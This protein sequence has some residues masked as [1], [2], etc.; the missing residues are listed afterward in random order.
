[1][2]YPHS[3]L[4]LILAGF[5]LV[6]MPLGLALWGQNRSLSELAQ[7]STKGVYETTD[8]ARLS[9][10]LMEQA[11]NM[12]RM[13]LGYTIVE[14]P[15]QIKVYA[16]A[17]KKFAYIE[18]QLTQRLPQSPEQDNLVKAINS[19]EQTLWKSLQGFQIEPDDGTQLTHDEQLSR[20]EQKEAIADKLKAFV[21][22]T[23]E[24]Q[25]L[26]SNLAQVSVRSLMAK[27][28]QA[29]IFWRVG[30][31][32]SAV[33][34]LI[35]AILMAI[36]IS[37]P[38]K[39]L[40]HA[41]RRL[42]TGNF[43]REIEVGGPKDLRLLGQ[44]LE[45]L[46]TR[47][48][49]LNDQQNRFLRNVSHDLKTP[50]TAI[51]EG[52]ELLRDGIAGTLHRRQYE[53]VVIIH[54]NALSLQKMIENLLNYQQPHKLSSDKLVKIDLSKAVKEVVNEH[55]VTAWRRL[56]KFDMH[57]ASIKVQ[58]E[59]KKIETIIDNLISNAVKYSP[60]LGTITLLLRVQNGFARLDVLDEGIGIPSDEQERVFDTFF[61][62]M[63]PSDKDQRVK[64]S[65]LGLAVAKEYALAHGGRVQADDRP[66]GKQGARFTVWLPVWQPGAE[67]NSKRKDKNEKK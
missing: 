23:L 39:A 55:R 25:N 60:R 26:A 57:L 7:Q 58:G 47:L 49:E 41:I 22:K 2:V 16:E 21:N 1:V 9:Q 54:D 3:L 34:A 14:D 35:F 63:P 6:A 15:Q 13:A 64:S 45:W 8:V 65:G 51:R 5:L 61:Q 32:A 10:Q 46:R 53:I 59:Q 48:Q 27:A 33:V 62:G 12:E 4:K 11:R 67:E 24:F 30:L 52:T 19:E 20:L 42:G 28:N 29:Q 44:R 17:R 56:I 50:L 38:I 31:W 18:Q 66:D 36:M 37:R 40:D 43:N